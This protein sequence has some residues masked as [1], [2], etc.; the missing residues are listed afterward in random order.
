MNRKQITSSPL[1]L[2]PIALLS[3][4]GAVTAV[5]AGNTNRTPIN[6]REHHQL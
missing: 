6:F 3:L 2:L 5:E 4:L 1:L